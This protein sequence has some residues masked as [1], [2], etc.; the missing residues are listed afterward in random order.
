MAD[1]LM[2]EE[3]FPLSPPHSSPFAIGTT[4]WQEK[5]AGGKRSTEVEFVLPLPIS[6]LPLWGSIPYG[7]GIRHSAKL[8][9]IF[10]SLLRRP[11]G[12]KLAGAEVFG[13]G[14]G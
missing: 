2:L 14:L 3:S 1:V 11:H 7:I 6:L 9:R 5:R 8:S 4:M 13:C 10:T 12:G